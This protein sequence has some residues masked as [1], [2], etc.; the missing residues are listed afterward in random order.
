M[1]QHQDAAVHDTRGWRSGGGALGRL[2]DP[3]RWQDTV[4]EISSR[5]IPAQ[6][7]REQASADMKR[8]LQAVLE[9]LHR[10]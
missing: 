1:M 7:P 8:I 2:P 10:A 4:R 9:G 5:P 6:D 3:D